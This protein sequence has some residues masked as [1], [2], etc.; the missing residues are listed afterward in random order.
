MLERL[1]MSKALS[2]VDGAA[3]YQYCRLFAETEAASD[4]QR[5]RVKLQK[6]LEASLS[7]LTGEALVEAIT[8]L[9]KLEQM[10]GRDASRIR[11]GRMAQ[12]V[13]LVE[14]G[15]TPASRG[16]VKLPDDPPPDP[17]DDF[18]DLGSPDGSTH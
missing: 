6:R 4:N 13:Y 7:D 9:V 14:F 10:E 3:L 15:L 1:R 12:R 2:T 17:F 18:D 8:E 11:M 16:R 5:R